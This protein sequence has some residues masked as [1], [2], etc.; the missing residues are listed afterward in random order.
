MEA[1]GGGWLRKESQLSAFTADYWKGK[2]TTANNIMPLSL[3]ISPPQLTSLFPRAVNLHIK[4]QP[5]WYSFCI[6]FF[7]LNRTCFFPNSGVWNTNLS[8]MK[9]YSI[10]LYNSDLRKNIF[11]SG[12]DYSLPSTTS[13]SL[14][15][16]YVITFIMVCLA[17]S[18]CSIHIFF[19]VIK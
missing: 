16:P 2:C 10:N 6:F 15:L 7:F 13:L 9:N 12:R 5:H 17:D 4:L 14:S 3:S 18:R 11:P 8:L 19:S 1:E